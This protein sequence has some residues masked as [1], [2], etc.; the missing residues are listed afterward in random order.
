MPAA[1]VEV[2]IAQG[3]NWFGYPGTEPLSL[4]D[5]NISPTTG[6]KVVSQDGGFA[7]YNGTA[8]EGTLTSLL[9]GKGYVYIS[10]DSQSKTITF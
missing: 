8:W 7:V 4:D 9:S 10:V 6:D 2:T 3:C 1:D 5:L